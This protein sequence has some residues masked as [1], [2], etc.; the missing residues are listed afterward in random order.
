MSNDASTHLTP[1]GQP[2]R[3]DTE[4]VNVTESSSNRI[5]TAPIVVD[6]GQEVSEDLS[7][8]SSNSAG[9]DWIRTLLTDGGQCR[10]RDIDLR[11][12]ERK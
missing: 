7:R 10:T 2:G 11:R 4:T 6:F 5:S 8:E 3:S 1:T 12:V 9:F